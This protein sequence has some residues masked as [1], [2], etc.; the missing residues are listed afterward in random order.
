MKK[1]SILFILLI[2]FEFGCQNATKNQST[3]KTVFITKK[4]TKSFSDLNKLD[5]FKIGLVG[6]K[7]EN[8]LLVFSIKNAKGEEIYNTKIKSED[9]LGSTDPNFDLSKE[10]DKIAFINNIANDFFNE[11]HFLEPAITE[12][13]K[14]DNYTPDK[15]FFNELKQTKLNGF[16]YRLGKE[17][18]IYIAWSVKEHKVKI[19]YNCC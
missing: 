4:V 5:T 12:D 10:E 2:V 14:I 16:T 6:T 7:P 13:Q 8:M 17:D 9:L 18:N 1:L 11:E 15:T 19:Y 3:N